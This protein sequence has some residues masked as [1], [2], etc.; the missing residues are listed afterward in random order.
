VFGEAS[1]NL[2][3]VKFRRKR[4]I[5]TLNAFPLRYYPDERG[6][7]A[8][9]IKCGRKFVSMLGAHYRY[10]RGTAFYIEDGEPVKVS[11]D[12]RVILNTTFFRKINPNYTRPQP[13]ELVR[14]KI[15]NNGYFDTFLES[16]SERT[17]D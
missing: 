9:L 7:K 16:S 2:A 10:Y 1:I 4:R 6:I 13:Y 15:D 8:G 11:I 14:K 5:N 12:S 3:I 17:L